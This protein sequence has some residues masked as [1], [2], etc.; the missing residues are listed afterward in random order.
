MSCTNAVLTDQKGI[1]AGATRVQYPPGVRDEH[2]RRAAAGGRRA[3]ELDEPR[4]RHHVPVEQGAAA[5]QT[6]ALLHL[7]IRTS[8]CSARPTNRNTA[9]YPVLMQHE[10][11][12]YRDG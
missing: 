3:A 7:R 2:G 9:L 11:A 8:V 1:Y 12:S 5:A 4:Q 10:T 6:Q